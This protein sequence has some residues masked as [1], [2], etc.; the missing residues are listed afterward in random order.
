M[1]V[2]R[3]AKRLKYAVLR[4]PFM[5]KYRL[6]LPGFELSESLRPA[7]EEFD[8]CLAGVLDG[9]A[10]RLEGKPGETA[11]SLEALLARLKEMADTCESAQAPG[12]LTGHPRTFVSL[13]RRIETLALSL[14]KEI[15][16]PPDHP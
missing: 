6:Q 12:L 7:Q 11:E 3:G 2:R 16:S 10:D 4:D 14:N 9:M 1:D 15:F 13:L 8:Q 5:L